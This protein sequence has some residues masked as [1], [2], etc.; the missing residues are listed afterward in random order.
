[1]VFISSGEG[2]GQSRAIGDYVG[3]SR[4]AT[5]ITNWAVAPDATSV[6]EIYPDDITEITA[7]PTAAAIADAVWDENTAGHTTGG[8]FGEQCKND[9]DAILTDTGTTL[10]AAL[11]VVD[12]NVDAIL[13]DT[14]TTLPATLGTPAADVSADIAAIKAETA[15]ILTD[16]GTTLDGKA[17]QIVAAVIT[18]AAGTDIAADIIAVKA[19]TAAILTDTG[20]TLD[21]ALA[22]VDGNV[23]AIKA[24][25]DSL[26]FTVAG[27]VDAN[28]LRINDVEI[29]GDGSGTPFDV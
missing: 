27:N 3:S 23:D 26:T 2:A 8:T 29:T 13:V 19:D 10:D 5:V 28:T 22:V 6:Y 7:A 14:G 12:A 4:Q 1:V 17:D 20:T 15:S 11:A 25:T 24:K 21:A 9:I 16:T 18:N